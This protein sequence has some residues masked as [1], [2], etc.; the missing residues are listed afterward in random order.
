MKTSI[1]F[2]T[3]LLLSTSVVAQPF[4]KKIDAPKNPNN[5]AEI[6][7]AIQILEDV[8]IPDIKEVG[9]S[10]YPGARIFQTTIAQSGRLPTV[11]LLS[12]DEVSV[13]TEFYKKEM[14]DWKSK[15]LYGT[16]TFFKGDEMEAMMGQAP[17]IQIG[18]ADM[19]SQTM[20]SAKSVITI[21][22][23]PIK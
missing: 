4:A 5:D 1:V 14:S 23:K 11:R 13:V 2:F 10:P 6:A 21:G 17:V 19:F 8:T 15:D 3:L 22:Y 18:S 12:A 16:Y 9:V 20:P 7:L